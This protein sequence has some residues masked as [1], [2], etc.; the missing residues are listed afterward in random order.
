MIVGKSVSGTPEADTLRT[1]TEDHL[2]EVQL[3]MYTLHVHVYI[4]Q[5][6]A[7]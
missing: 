1:R 7:L 3:D 4:L 5:L 6:F 2:V